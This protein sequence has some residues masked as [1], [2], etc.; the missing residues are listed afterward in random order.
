VDLAFEFAF[1]PACHT[2]LIL[3]ELSGVRFFHPHDGTV[4]GPRKLGMEWGYSGCF[5]FSTQWVE[6]LLGGKS[7]FSTQRV[8]NGR[9]PFLKDL[10]E[11][12]EEPEIRSRIAGTVALCQFGGQV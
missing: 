6:N 11:L 7:R 4:V 5:R 2:A 9:L 10:I 8:E 3:I 12:A 1:R